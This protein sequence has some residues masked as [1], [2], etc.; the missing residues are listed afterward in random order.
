MD[1]KGLLSQIL[2]PVPINKHS[3]EQTTEGYQV[4][5]GHVAHKE[6]VQHLRELQLAQPQRNIY[7]FAAAFK[8]TPSCVFSLHWPTLIAYAE[9]NSIPGKI[10]M[11]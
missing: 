3:S 11:D 2:Q 6:K 8:L 10:F 9:E 4:H 1:C 5:I 7:F